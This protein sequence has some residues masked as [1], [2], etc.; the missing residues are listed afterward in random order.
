MRSLG[1][2][3]TA[4]RRG[5]LREHAS[6][7]IA[8]VRVKVVLGSQDLTRIYN[9]LIIK[10]EILLSLILSL[11]KLSIPLQTKHEKVGY[12]TDIST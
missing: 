5:W 6:S 10:V 11:L 4:C 1:G 8:Q 2:M 3:A 12:E 9:K 7:S